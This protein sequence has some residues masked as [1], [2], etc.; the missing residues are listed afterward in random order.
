MNMLYIECKMGIAGDMLTAALLELISD[1]EEIIST[2]NNMGLEGVSFSLNASEKCGIMGS[3]M[4]VTVN[5]E[6]EVS[7]DY[8][9]DHHHDEHDHDH[10]HDHHHDGHDHDHHHHD[11][12]EHDHHHH[13]GHEHDHHGHRGIREIEEIVSSLKIPEK[14]KKDVIR[15]Y[16]L[17]AEAESHV[18]GTKVSEI[19]FHEVGNLDAIADITAV[20]LLMDRLSPDRVVVSPIHVGSGQVKCAHGILPVPTPATAFLLK[21]IPTYS[22]DIRGEL[23]TPTGAALAKYFASEFGPQPVMEISSIGYGMGN[24]D[25]PQ[26]NCVRVMLGQSVEKGSDSVIELVCNLDDMTPEEVGFATE[27]LMEEG[28]LDV[29]TTSIYM[30]KNR[31]GFMLTVLCRDDRKEHLV[32]MIFKHTTT[33]GIRESICSRYILDRMETTAEIAGESVRVKNVSGYGV[34]R[35]KA[36]YDDLAE[37]ARKKDLGLRDLK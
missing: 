5:G 1:K 24:K 13:E 19:H 26:A 35:S 15:V 10:Y 12:G 9:H 20:C 6:E 22:G 2:L 25:F 18:H 7:Y 21:G 29:F 23:C 33:I 16:G 37:I 4:T 36:E 30:K 3:H 11:H 14:V 8:N 17:I 28:A 27:K 34:S 31:P 32:Q